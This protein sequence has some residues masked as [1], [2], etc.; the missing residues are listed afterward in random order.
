[1]PALPGL[2]PRRSPHQGYSERLG[3]VV[4]LDYHYFDQLKHLHAHQGLNASQIAR[5]LTLAPRTVAYWRTPEPLRPRQPHARSSKLAPFKQEMGRMRDRY[6]SS[7]AQGF[8]R[9]RAHGFDGGYSL[10]KA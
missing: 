3:G 8:Q 10:V 9:L 7:A 2:S 6:P 5:E 4:R 1:M